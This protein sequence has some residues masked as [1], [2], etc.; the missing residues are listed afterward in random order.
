MPLCHAVA[1]LYGNVLKGVKNRLRNSL[2]ANELQKA[3]FQALKG[4]LSACKRWPFGVQKVAFR[5]SAS[6]L[7]YSLRR[8]SAA[9]KG[10]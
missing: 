9:H 6:S 4:G 3:S 10:R 5:I 1:G 8:F 7:P 2:A